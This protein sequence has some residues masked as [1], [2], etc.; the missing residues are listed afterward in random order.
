MTPSP[1]HV[2]LEEAR[3]WLRRLK[4]AH[5]GGPAQLELVSSQ[6]RDSVAPPRATP[7][8]AEG[9][10]AKVAEAFLRTLETRRKRPEVARY[11]IEKD[12]LP[13]IGALPLRSL[14]KSDCRGVVAK[15]VARGAKGHAGKVL[16]I[17]RQMLDYAENVED[18][19][20]NP[21]ARLKASNLEIETGTR[22]RWLDE[23]EI[24][25]FWKALTPSLERSQGGSLTPEPQT[26]AALRILLIT[27]A[28]SGELRIARW[29]HVDLNQLT[30]TIPPE[31]QKLPPK[32]ARTA[33]PFVIP[34]SPL[35][36]AQ[37]EALRGLAGQ[38]PYIL[39]G[40]DGKPY[41]TRSLGRAMARLWE[42]KL[43]SLDPASP[44]DLR[45]TARTWFGKL[46]IPPHIAERCLN[47]R[48]GK[49]V[50]TYDQG[51]YL[52]ERRAALELWDAHI[53]TLITG[54][55]S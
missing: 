18:D 27:A 25:L 34:L 32:L 22:D 5:R 24:P 3:E 19:F 45:R 47:H 6:L 31:N 14:K 26:T 20:M 40:K 12:I 16:A 17:L 53:R 52:A 46:G 10:V 2:T 49:I 38:S 9:T 23:T 35:A 7:E 44:H 33:K 15:V 28:R 51:D 8:I 39:P 4:T 50:A 11:L 43:S 21:A 42:R 41:D 37:F 1:G 29:E 36:L 30:W 13:F 48:L 54:S 55:H